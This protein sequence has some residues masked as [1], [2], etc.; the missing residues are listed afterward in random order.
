VEPVRIGLIG[1]GSIAQ[2]AH[3]PAIARLP[4][5]V[6]LVAAADVRAE[7]AQAAAAPFGADAYSDYRQVVARPDVDMVILCTPEFAH[8]EQ[9]EAAAA[10]GKHVLSEKPMAKTLPEADAMID[11]ARR[12]GTRLMIGHSRRFTGRYQEVRRAIDAGEIGL[13]RV[14]RENERRSRPPAG[15]DSTYWNPQH[16]TG[17]PRYSVGAILTNGI[18]EADLFRWF[19]GAEP[20]RVYAEHKTTRPG[21]LVPD[22]ITFTVDFANGAVA[23]GE[24]SNCLPPGYPSY[25]QLEIHGTGGVVRAKDHDQQALVRFRDTGADYPDSYRLLLHVQDAYVSELAQFVTAMREDH[26]VPL[27]AEE[28]R[29]ALRLGLAADESARIGRPVDLAAQ[30]GG[31]R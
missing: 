7:A 6:R 2:S 9:V 28:A 19:A 8:R 1:C 5:L 29:E 17:D 20:V 4:G 27:P 11:A 26:P 15:R 21:N 13:V 25:H 24:V 16:W 22:F 14:V 10:A 18:H 31:R 12:A 30:G 23:S 3:L